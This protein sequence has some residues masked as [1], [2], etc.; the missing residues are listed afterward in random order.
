MGVSPSY[1]INST[2]VIF[3]CVVDFYRQDAR[4]SARSYISVTQ[5][6]EFALRR[7]YLNFRS[8]LELE[9]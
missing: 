4:L 2:T 6:T 1:R 3:P 8:V 9:A 5:L 7:R